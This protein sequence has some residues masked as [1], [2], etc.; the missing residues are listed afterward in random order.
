MRKRVFVC[1]IALGCFLVSCSKEEDVTLKLVDQNFIIYSQIESECLY[2][3]VLELI[4]QNVDMR[5]FC[6]ALDIS[7]YK[8][9]SNSLYTVIRTTN[10]YYVSLFDEEGGSATLLPIRFSQSS[11]QEQVSNLRVGMTLSDARKADPNG[12]Y[13]FIYHS[14]SGYPCISYH[15]FENGYCYSI[16]YADNSI[17]NIICFTI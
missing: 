10:G 11:D 2:D 15:Y 3:E 7:H 16:E 13:D 4:N 9:V 1:V 17:S 6:K 5:T 14:W 8:T 12:Q